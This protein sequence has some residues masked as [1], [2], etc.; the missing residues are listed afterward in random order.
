M[1][2]EEGLRSKALYKAGLSVIKVIPVLTALCYLTNTVLSYCGLDMPLL[3]IIAGMSL[4]PLLFLYLSSYMFR[5][6]SYHRMP[7][8]YILVSDILN[9]YD[10][11]LGIPLPYRALFCVHCIIAWFFLFTTLHLKFKVCRTH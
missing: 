8:H 1:A 3:S 11:Y 9:I 5:F 7:L 6:C 2:V 4:L 10:E